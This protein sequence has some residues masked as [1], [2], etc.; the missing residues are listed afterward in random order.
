MGEHWDWT[1][2]KVLD[3]RSGFKII[4]H[5]EDRVVGQKKVQDAAWK[6]KQRSR[7]SILVAVTPYNAGMQS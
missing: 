6:E 7:G 5:A 3:D 4:V 1:G 2:E